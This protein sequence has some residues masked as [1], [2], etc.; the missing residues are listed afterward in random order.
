MS[1]K[2][3]FSDSFKQ[4]HYSSSIDF[5]SAVL[6][7]IPSF[8]VT[9]DKFAIYVANDCIEAEKCGLVI[10]N[11][12]INANVNRNP[13]L[14]SQHILIDVARHPFLAYDSF[15]DC[16]SI[17]GYTKQSLVNYI[18]SDPKKLVGNV[19]DDLMDQIIQ[20]L[21]SSKTIDKNT[22]YR[23]SLVEK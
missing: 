17:K 20:M 9:Y 7:K 16:T 3:F 19:Q 1:L 14:R 22:K 6:V 4:T 8:S 2:D 21:R 15:V 12:E 10:I 13:Y 23:Y 11:S 5:G 18:V